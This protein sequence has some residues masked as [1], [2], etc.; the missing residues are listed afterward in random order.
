MWPGQLLISFRERRRVFSLHILDGNFAILLSKLNT[1]RCHRRKE[2]RWV[3]FCC[4]RVK[5]G[6]YTGG[7]GNGEKLHV[8]SQ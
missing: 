4:N 3:S 1:T 8:K 6:C 5:R 7:G 2:N